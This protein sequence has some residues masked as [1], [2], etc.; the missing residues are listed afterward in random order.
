VAIA[1]K[2]IQE[3]M[4]K[5][6][7]GLAAYQ[8]LLDK[9]LAKDPKGRVQNGVELGAMIQGLSGSS[10]I[11]YVEIRPPAPAVRREAPPAPQKGQ[12]T[13]VVAPPDFEA[14]PVVPAAP[15]RSGLVFAL[16]AL[17]G[18]LVVVLF[19]ILGSGKKEPQRGPVIYHPYDDS[20]RKPP[21]V[22]LGD[23]GGQL[24]PKIDEVPPAA[25]TLSLRS[26]Y[27]VMSY[28]VGRDMLK[29]NNFYDKSD[30]P[31]ATGI[32]HQYEARTLAGGRVVVDHTTGLMWHQSGADGNR[33]FPEARAWVDDLN[34]WGYA[35]YSDWRLPTLEEAASLVESYMKNG[36][37][38]VDPVF[39]TG[40]LRIWTGDS[41]SASANWVARFDFGDVNYYR[42]G[43]PNHVR[44]VRA[45]R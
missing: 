8:P 9:L 15:K 25:P 34:R 23:N 36:S 1:I 31:G 21:K 5:L 37:L 27:I 11:P 16:F 10:S 44:P 45:A 12:P 41:F 33:N 4:P 20:G 32:R 19:L 7:A 28:E 42:H 38:Y 26:Y 2:H 30:N 35:G 3:P 39:S 17:L 13:R 14:K 40:Q 6:P 24:P 43:A 29:R 18:V 22:D